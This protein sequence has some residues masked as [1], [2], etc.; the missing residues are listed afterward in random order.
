MQ[1]T[2]KQTVIVILVL[3]ILSSWKADLKGPW[4]RTDGKRIILYTRPLNYSKT[5]SPDSISIRKII[6]EQEHA[7][8]YI[9]DRLKT[10]FQSKVEIF[11]Y[12]LDEAKE[13]IGTNG[14]GFAN[15]NKSKRQIYFTYRSEPMF[16]TIKNT[17]EYVGVHEM[18]HVITINKLGSLNT[19]FFGEGYSNALDGN[20]GSQMQGNRLAWCR[21]DSTLVKIMKMGKLLKPS[22][23][24]YNE[25]IPVREFYPQ[26]GCLVN[27][28][29]ETYG[30]DKINKLYSLKREEIEVGFLKATGERFEEMEKRYMKYRQVN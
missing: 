11:L 8:D 27:W 10:D 18:V 29:F 9:N 26:V 2:M 5:E 6:Q 3:F 25:N 30:V 20:C 4:I 17:L 13:K 21:N 12:N 14:G 15:L 16:N 22:D 23:L 1:K 7:I 28:L 24:L 19:S